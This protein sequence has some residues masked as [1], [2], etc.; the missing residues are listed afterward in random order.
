MA[1]YCEE[2]ENK[3]YVNK[4]FTLQEMCHAINFR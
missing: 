1:Y 4:V 2:T 3:Q